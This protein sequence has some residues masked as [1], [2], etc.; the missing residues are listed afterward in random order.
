MAGCGGLF[1]QLFHAARGHGVPC[2]AAG[3]LPEVGF[4]GK[5]AGR[6]A[7]AGQRPGG[8]L[9]G[10]LHGGVRFGRGDGRARQVQDDN[11]QGGGVDVDADGV[12]AARPEPQHPARPPAPLTGGPPGLDD[13][14]PADE[15]ADAVGDRLRDEPRH[16]AQARPGEA[17]RGVADGLQ[18][19][20]SVEVPDSGEVA[21]ASHGAPSRFRVRSGDGTH[22]VG[23]ARQ[24]GRR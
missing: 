13:E 2:L 10:A 18:D 4:G 17:A 5:A 21:P 15:V 9:H 14:A 19:D 12:A 6:A 7:V 8:A 20:C 1:V 23:R 11:A 16:P 3:A 22:I 24:A